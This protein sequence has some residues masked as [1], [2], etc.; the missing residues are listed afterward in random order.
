VAL[1]GVPRFLPDPGVLGLPFGLPRGISYFS[2]F[3]VVGLAFGSPVG[4]RG[5]PGE[6][7]SHDQSQ[8]AAARDDHAG[9]RLPRISVATAVK[10]LE[11]QEGGFPPAFWIGSHNGFRRLPQTQ[12]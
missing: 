6:K 10:L 2:Y 11:G 7:A 3:H 1:F 4:R 12:R 5:A 9:G 8:G